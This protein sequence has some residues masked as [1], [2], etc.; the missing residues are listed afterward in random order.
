MSRLKSGKNLP[1]RLNEVED[2]VAAAEEFH[3]HYSVEHVPEDD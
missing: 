2:I 1:I 3:S